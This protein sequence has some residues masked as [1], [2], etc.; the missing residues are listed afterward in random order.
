[1][2][3]LTSTKTILVHSFIHNCLAGSAF[4]WTRWKKK[5]VNSFCFFGNRFINNRGVHSIFSDGYIWFI[6][7]FWPV[8]RDNLSFL[9]TFSDVQQTVFWY[10][11]W[12]K[13]QKQSR[14]SPRN[15][16]GNEHVKHTVATINQVAGQIQPFAE[17]FRNIAWT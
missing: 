14:K 10:F 9:I 11:F 3:F 12:E 4:C 17:R 15:W 8:Q 13:S 7:I 2:W 6:I 16:P 5:Q 1:M